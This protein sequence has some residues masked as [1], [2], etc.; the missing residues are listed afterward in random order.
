M[1]ETNEP[2]KEAWFIEWAE[3]LGYD[4]SSPE[5]RAAAEADIAEMRRLIAE[6]LLAIRKI[7][8]RA[9]K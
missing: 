5:G 8:R 7:K 6:L 2:E 4:L 1:S 3:F 9:K